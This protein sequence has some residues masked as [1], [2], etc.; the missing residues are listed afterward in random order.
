MMYKG[1]KGKY[2]S[3]GLQRT[4]SMAF[5]VRGTV[6][7]PDSEAGASWYDPDQK[8]YYAQA[9]LTKKREPMT[10]PLNTALILLCVL[11]VAFGV[12]TLSRTVRKAAIAKD[13][14]AMD[15]AIQKIQND[16]AELIL[17]V[18]EA[19][20]MA[21]IGYDAAHRLN[22]VEAEKADTIIVH[23]PDTRPFESSDSAAIAGSKTGSR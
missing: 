5:G 8:P 14:S 21:R 22:M 16:N 15:Q 10:L 9:V 19:R 3:A 1:S 20:D 7:L 11:F 12:M 18:T 6:H 2:V 4:P 13:I 17:K 23:A